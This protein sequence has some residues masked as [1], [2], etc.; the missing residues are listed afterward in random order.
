M[1]LLFHNP[2]SKRKKLRQT[3]TEIKFDR[4]NRHHTTLLTLNRSA[5]HIVY[6]IVIHKIT[7]RNV[8]SFQIEFWQ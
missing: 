7:W 1:L 3:K 2:V 6:H 8:Q 5:I 4:Q